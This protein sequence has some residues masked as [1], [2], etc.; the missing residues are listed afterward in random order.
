MDASPSYYRNPSPPSPTSTCS[1]S[2]NTEPRDNSSDADR[3]GDTVFSKTWVLALLVKAL[4]YVSPRKED[5]GAEPQEEV[6]NGAEPQTAASL[7]EDTGLRDSPAPPKEGSKVKNGTDDCEE[8]SD[9]IDPSLEEG[10]CLL[11]DASMNNVGQTQ[12]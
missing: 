7:S 1:P 6:S 5:N 11:W 2:G 3:I 9:I 10:L 4:E 8:R 12:G